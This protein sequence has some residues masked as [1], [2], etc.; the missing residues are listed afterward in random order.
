MTAGFEEWFEPRNTRNTRTKEKNAAVRSARAD[1]FSAAQIREA[2]LVL[3]DVPFRA[4]RVFRGSSFESFRLRGS[5]QPTAAR[6]FNSSPLV[7]GG[8]PA[9]ERQNKIEQHLKGHQGHYEILQMGSDR[10]QSQRIW[11]ARDS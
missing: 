6:Q 9:T 7:G 10:Q 5:S 2:L 4:F 8:P 1:R 11:R 3:T